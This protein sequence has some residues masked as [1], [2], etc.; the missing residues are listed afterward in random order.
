MKVEQRDGT[1]YYSSWKYTLS[2]C[3][4]IAAQDTRFYWKGT[5][6][7]G[8]DAHAWKNRLLCAVQRG[9]EGC[10]YHCTLYYSCW[11]YRVR[12]RGF[13]AKSTGCSVL[14]EGHG[15]RKER[16]LIGWGKRAKSRVQ[17]GKLWNG[18]SCSCKVYLMCEYE[19]SQ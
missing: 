17:S 18:A 13:I 15:E 6:K 8:K 19:V 9:I 5:E 14:L 3:R 4:F 7:E 10:R 16:L 2:A 1:P 11:K 12:T